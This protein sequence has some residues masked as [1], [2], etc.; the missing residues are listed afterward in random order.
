M[1]KKTTGNLELV[2]GE[3]LENIFWCYTFIIFLCFTLQELHL[4]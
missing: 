1:A 3:E 4:L 2:V